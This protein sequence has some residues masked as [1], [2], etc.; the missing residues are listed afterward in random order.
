MFIALLHKFGCCVCFIYV[1]YMFMLF[2]QNIELSSYYQ[3]NRQCGILW[4]LN[5][6]VL[7]MVS[8]KDEDIH[9]VSTLKRGENLRG[10][11]ANFQQVYFLLEVSTGCVATKSHLAA[12][13]SEYMNVIQNIFLDSI[14]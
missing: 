9:I 14:L 1:I 4:L 8:I 12:M 2:S 6:L 5:Q 11:S 13:L 10:F 7:P 3:S